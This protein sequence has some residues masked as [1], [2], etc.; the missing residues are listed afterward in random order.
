MGIA[1][2]GDLKNALRDWLDNDTLDSRADGFIGLV[3]ARCN[4]ILRAPEMEARTTL[5]IGGS[6]ANSIDLPSDF[7][8]LRSVHLEDSP[9]EPLSFRSP[10]FVE[11]V[12]DGL[13]GNPKYY[14]V[15]RQVLTFAPAAP[16]S[17]DFSVLYFQA[18]P[19]LTE[20]NTTNWLLTANPDVY[21][22]GVLCQAEGYAVND[23]RVAMWKQLLD[24]ALG[25]MRQVGDIVRL[26]AENTTRRTVRKGAA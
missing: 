7:L 12:R 6:P 18:I 22:Y 17:T 23:N 20:S 24:E 8:E 16:A 15:E 1:T 21:V 25:E 3:E 2:Y 13:S 26:G 19:G 11:S 9:D 5:T 14:S 4:R 10:Q